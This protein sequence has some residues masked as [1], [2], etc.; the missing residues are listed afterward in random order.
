MN[1]TIQIPKFISK[2][3]YYISMFFDIL[4]ILTFILSVIYY[5]FNNSSLKP[6]ND[7]LFNLCCLSIFLNSIVK[8]IEISLLKQY[9]EDNVKL[10]TEQVEDIVDITKL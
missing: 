2:T 9:L 5:M 1:F 3:I 4:L 8:S 10:T 6:F 7:S